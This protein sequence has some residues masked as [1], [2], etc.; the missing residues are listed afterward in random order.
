MIVHA[1]LKYQHLRGFFFLFPIWLAGLALAA[2]HA[3]VH[4]Q[5]NWIGGASGDW[6]IASNWSTNVV[7]GAGDDVL[8]T[9]G[10]FAPSVMNGSGATVA[11]LN[12]GGQ[13]DANTGAIVTGTGSLGIVNGAQLTNNANSFFGTSVGVGTGSV[14]T[15]VI[16]G[17]G[18][19]WTSGSGVLVGA[20]GATGSLMLEN[21]GTAVFGALIVGASL[22]DIIDAG[23][24]N[25]SGP[26]T[27]TLT[28]TGG[29]QLTAG[30][31]VD[32]GAGRETSGKATVSGAGS[33]ISS[34][35]G[36]LVG[37]L[38][39]GGTFDILDGGTLITGSNGPYSF[40]V[41][42]GGGPS[43]LG[44]GPA[45][46]GGAGAMTISGAGSTWT[47][48]GAIYVGGFVDTSQSTPALY[49]G[50]G[51]LTIADGA[52]M[53][54]IGGTNGGL[55]DAI[56][57]GQGSLGTALVTGA[58]SQ[59]TAGQHL[60]AGY[61][62]GNGTLTIEN[63]G[64]V[65]VAGIMG[66]GIGV[67]SFTQSAGAINV[68]NGGT[69]ISNSG[70]FGAIGGSNFGGVVG[71]ADSTGT[72]LVSD[73]DSSWII[74][75]GLFVGGATDLGLDAGAGTVTIA[76][77]GAIRASDGVT[78]APGACSFGTLNIGAAPGS[79]AVAPGTLDTPTVIFGNGTGAINFNHTAS[80]YLFAA[81]ISGSGAVNQI[82]G[83]TILTGDS[84]Y[85]DATTISGGLLRVNGSLGN[86][87]VTVGSGGSLGG[88]GSIAGPVTVAAGGI[89]AP[90]NAI[91][92]LTLGGDFTQEAGTIYRIEINTAGQSD[93]VVVGGT[94][95]IQN[96]ATLQLVRSD[97]ATSSFV[98]GTRYTILTAAGGVNGTW[99]ILSGDA[100]TAFIDLGFGQNANAA[101]LDALRNTVRFADVGL[102]ANQRATGAAVENLGAANPLYAAIVQSITPQA[103]RTAFDLASGEIHAG[104]ASA[105]FD[106]SRA[107]RTAIL[108]RLRDPSM[109]LSADLPADFSD[110]AR[111]PSPD[112]HAVW[113]QVF[114]DYGRI[115]GNDNAA[116][117]NR[118]LG[119]LIIGA[120]LR[121]ADHY[122]AGIAGGYTKSSL[123]VDARA[124]SGS[125]E[126]TFGGV[127]GGA[128]FG[129][130]RLRTGVLYADN[131]YET[132]RSIV[133]PG[134][135][136]T[137]RGSYSGS[138]AQAF[139]EAGWRMS[140][141]DMTI[142]PFA[143]LSLIHIYMHAFSETGEAAALQGQ[144]RSYDYQAA[145]TGVRVAS[146]PLT[147]PILRGALGWQH[148]FGDAAPASVLAF[149][150]ADDA[151]TPFSITGAPVVR[152]SLLVEAGIEW[153]HARGVSSGIFYAGVIGQDA[154]TNALQGRLT[155]EF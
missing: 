154:Y 83:T 21:E 103:A 86:T 8:I 40:S 44:T 128:D 148:I 25:S 132:K 29:S 17:A 38:G 68:L 22:N 34:D 54:S 145:T 65:D 113:S 31:F 152:D 136:E 37:V 149:N 35:G 104:M 98:V 64:T 78:L 153:R 56:G 72:V 91:G 84:T 12:I 16:A 131:R 80:D 26:S 47:N 95:T 125:I 112:A 46:N 10:S 100:T 134:F 138:T 106:D 123:D 7:P 55:P 62:G 114:G 90:G 61:G 71:G 120:D 63:G 124:S 58:G 79:T 147:G 107:P 74:N 23:L 140:A 51:T 82:A 150:D 122:R 81:D 18:S 9:A 130:L 75:G 137:A 30:V 48:T 87:A 99:S 5:T 6:F 57:M 89:I 43:H 155:M 111:Q 115:G 105:A 143:G 60:I 67:A 53:T 144:S 52:K 146:A 49:P 135:Q 66:A 141:S 2:F 133:F 117:I 93:L 13:F 109:N 4:A 77:G 110:S 1:L 142:E 11:G 96:G 102:S 121:L 36:I 19:N 45:I 28:V 15:M 129:P 39:G 50:I 108:D 69:L 20:G 59:W 3:P 116:A 97:A 127:Y 73:A 70:G 94:A 118:S 151:A 14:G 101:Y 139:A 33:I 76:N 24:T 126:S 41:I 85:T 27:G 32:V 92:T 42:G 119:G 88:T